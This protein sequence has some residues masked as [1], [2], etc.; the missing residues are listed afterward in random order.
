MDECPGCGGPGGASLPLGKAT[1]FAVAVGPDAFTQPPYEVRECRRCGLLFRSPRL[2]DAML[3]VYYRSALFEDFATPGFG[4]VERAIHDLL[5]SLPPGARVLDFGCNTGRLLAPVTDRFECYG[6]E[7][8][9]SAAAVARQRGLRMTTLEKLL[10]GAAGTFGAVIAV[11]VFE[12]LTAPM[13][14][15]ACFRRLLR[16]GGALALVT[17]NGDAPICRLGPAE[18]WYFRH[19]G[20]VVMLTR[21]FAGYL[22]RELGFRLAAWSEMSRYDGSRS[23][24]LLQRIRSWA[25]WSF[26]RDTPLARFGLGHVPRL[27]RARYWDNAPAVM[28]LADHVMAV[29]A[30]SERVAVSA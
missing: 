6:V 13:P 5:G 10:A 22:D 25:Y 16:P 29:F 18:F 15:L 14:I 7:P 8:N 4:P 3:E 1:G 19:I 11:D 24:A 17:G 27:R 23:A 26:K 20:H 12:H 2:T 9:P 21:S 28:D 30:K